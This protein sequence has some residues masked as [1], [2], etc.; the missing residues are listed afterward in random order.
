M[1]WDIERISAGRLSWE[2]EDVPKEP[3]TDIT[4]EIKLL[5]KDQYLLIHNMIYFIIILF[6][7]KNVSNHILGTEHTIS[8]WAG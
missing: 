7:Y 6:P 3:Y 1:Q 4:D 5:K 2:M 8:L